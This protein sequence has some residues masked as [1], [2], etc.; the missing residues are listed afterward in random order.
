MYSDEFKA[1]VI[2]FY[3]SG[4][5]TLEST[6][7]KFNISTTSVK[8]WSRPCGPRKTTGKIRLFSKKE[9]EIIRQMR[10]EDPSSTWK[11]FAQSVK[12]RLNVNKGSHTTIRRIAVSC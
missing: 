7:E 11:D 1:E 12:A 2:K 6:A 9:E 10:K 5:G 8:N 3:L 4:Q